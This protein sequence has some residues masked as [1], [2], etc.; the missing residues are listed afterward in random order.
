[1]SLS[2]L[3]Q[4]CCQLL[5]PADLRA[6]KPLWHIC[7]ISSSFI[8]LVSQPH[9]SLE[10]PPSQMCGNNLWDMLMLT[11]LL[12]VYQWWW[13]YWQQH[14]AVGVSFSLPL[15]LYHCAESKR[16]SGEWRRESK[17]LPPTELDS[18]LILLKVSIDTKGVNAIWARRLRYIH[19]Q[20]GPIHSAS[21]ATAICSWWEWVGEGTPC[22]S[23]TPMRSP[24]YRIPVW[25]QHNIIIRGTKIWMK[26][27]HVTAGADWVMVANDPDALQWE[28]EH[29]WRQNNGEKKATAV[30][31]GWRRLERENRCLHTAQRRRCTHRAT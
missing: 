29:V 10:L 4:R 2:D 24:K 27:I 26:M 17:G 12:F 14:V 6:Q 16:Q 25:Y 5:P 8:K 21:P 13:F 18:A 7:L 23:R 20:K 3:Q 19:K 22:T 1:M 30:A 31:T 9:G 15:F 28:R 11:H